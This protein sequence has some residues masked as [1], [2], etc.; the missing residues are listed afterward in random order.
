MGAPPPWRTSMK[1][2]EYSDLD[3]SSVKKQ[4]Q[5]IIHFLEQ[6]D[7]HSAEVKKLVEQDY[8]RA[9]LDD[10]NRLLFKI[11]HYQGERYALI[12][13]V[14]HQHTYEKSRFLRGAKIDEAKISLITPDQVPDTGLPELSYVNPDSRHV[15]F[16]DKIISFDPDQR[17][18]YNLPLPLIVIGPAGSGK[19]AL[20]L[21]KMKQARGR[22]LYITLSP[23]LVENSRN[24]YYAHH[25]ENEDQ[26]LAFL[27]FREYLETIRVP[28]GRE[29]SYSLFV[30]W[31]SRFPKQ[32][33]VGDAHK[34]YEEFRGVIT[35]PAVDKPFLSRE[36][37]LELGV[38]QSIFLAR[39]AGTSLCLIRKISEFF[40]GTSAV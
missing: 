22:I 1:I 26:E 38:R 32:Q 9:K 18:I 7:F 31:L 40:E 25:Y 27:S 4:Y 11:V 17:E 3:F 39:R 21:E 35:G 36:D 12:L 20:T 13:E 5:K 10:T 16:L 15:Q 19:T 6:D 28:E 30:G 8:Y 2:L 29:I 37:Y 14:I 24:L 34:L 23:Y 33:R